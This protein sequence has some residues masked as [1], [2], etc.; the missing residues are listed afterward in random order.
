MRPP[1]SSL[2]IGGLVS[3]F[4]IQPV[5]AQDGAAI[6]TGKEAPGPA[7][8]DAAS[9]LPSE[10]PE[11][12][13]LKLDPAKGG[14]DGGMLLPNAQD[15]FLGLELFLGPNTVDWNQLYND[16]SLHLDVNSLTSEVNMSLAIGARVVDGILA[17]Q[18]QN[19]EALNESAAEIE[20]LARRLGVGEGELSRAQD[21]QRAANKKDW[22]T[23]FSEIGRLQ[24]DVIRSLNAKGREDIRPLVIAGGWTQG[25]KYM[26]QLIDTHYSPGA[27]NFL[28][29]PGIVAQLQQEMDKLKPDTRANPAVK[30]IV[31]ALPEIHS[32]VDIPKD[33]AVP[34]DQVKR[35][36]DL[37]TSIVTTF[38][39]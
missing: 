30:A 5:P 2:A 15:K 23:V 33:G 21:V 1:F 31:E 13:P 6:P 28:R 18:A 3:L 4:L 29:E 26:A 34:Q 22:L 16:G 19:L 39:N 38:S 8:T 9:P 10:K 7:S 36:R 14:S 20:Q 24:A 32:M 11:F 37:S 35:L 12:D 17:L 27:S 25:A